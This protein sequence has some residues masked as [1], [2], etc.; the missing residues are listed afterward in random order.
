MRVRALQPRNAID[1]INREVEPID[2]IAYCELKRC[3]DVAFLFV[4]TD[5]NVAVICPSVGK[6]MS[7]PQ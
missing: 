3:V 7:L 5:M 2:L 6:F 4:P 1:N